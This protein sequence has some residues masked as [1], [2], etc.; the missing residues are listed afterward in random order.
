MENQRNNQT[1]EFS[2]ED[3]ERQSNM[4]V[5]RWKFRETVKLG[6]SKIEIQRENS[7]LLGKNQ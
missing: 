7:Q 2:Y 4:G 1:W 5:F 6:N 3:S